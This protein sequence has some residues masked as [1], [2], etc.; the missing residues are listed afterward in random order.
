MSVEAAANNN[1]PQLGPALPEYGQPQRN[2]ATPP[3]YSQRPV[4]V[5]PEPKKIGSR[6]FFV[7]R[8]AENKYEVKM[9]FTVKNKTM[10]SL[11]S[12]FDTI[13]EAS[14]ILPKILQ[15]FASK[16]KPSIEVILGGD[17][18]LETVLKYLNGTHTLG[19]IDRSAAEE[20]ASSVNQ[21]REGLATKLDSL[22]I[23]QARILNKF[24][25]EARDRGIF[26]NDTKIMSI[27]L[28]EA[29]KIIEN[30]NEAFKTLADGKT[31]EFSV[32]FSDTFDALGLYL[33]GKLMREI[34][35]A[36]LT[37]DA[38]AANIKGW[39]NNLDALPGFRMGK[40][41]GIDAD[42]QRLHQKAGLLKTMD[43]K[44]EGRY[45]MAGGL[46][47]LQFPLD[48][49]NN[50]LSVAVS[51]RKALAY[52]KLGDR[53][54]ISLRLSEDL[55]N[56]RL[57]L[58]GSD[59]FG[60]PVADIQDVSNFMSSAIS[61]KEAINNS[62]ISITLEG[63]QPLVSAVKL[64]EIKTKPD[65][66]KFAVFVRGKLIMRCDD[67][68]TASA[69]GL[70]IARALSQVEE[71]KPPK[72]EA[73]FTSS[74]GQI[75]FELYLNINGVH[76][77]NISLDRME[78]LR[79]WG[80]N[81]KE[82]LQCEFDPHGIDEA[83][84]IR[85]AGI[86]DAEALFGGFIKPV[87]GPYGSPWGMRLH[88]IKHVYKLHTGQDIKA[89]YGAIVRAAAGGTVIKAGR[90]GDYGNAVLIDHGNGYIT[91]Y[92]HMSKITTNEGDI[93]PQGFKIGNVGSTGSST[94]P[95]LH[96]GMFKGHYSEGASVNPRTGQT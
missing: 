2:V 69:V 51:I 24:K 89:P 42:I 36:S 17:G 27:S 70:N 16:E 13:K 28:D 3:S 32:S 6:T 18:M 11:L 72:L 59:I 34:N 21:I 71:G 55:E 53:P 83:R 66:G 7:E 38:E 50:A 29:A 77:K 91:L 14:C 68:T 85:D 19:K 23:R 45:V 5:L 30:I 61:M 87:S 8:T 15:A 49:E 62:F 12:R 54:V 48:D 76:I 73:S 10:V 80:A 9:S 67:I 78:E 26:V 96:F 31:A 64:Y 65:E 82:A 44:V 46:K 39:I 86:G 35:I 56:V 92:G 52:A 88:P 81:L 33:N 20:L 22:G 4:E 60:K 90:M 41:T 43:I 95:H 79:I 40:N 75:N 74:S 93:I 37:F 58:N 1:K 94:G 63:L 47:V 57:T 25:V 84:K